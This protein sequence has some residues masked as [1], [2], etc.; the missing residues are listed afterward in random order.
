[1]KKKK[2]LKCLYFGFKMPKLAFKF[3]EMDPVG[4]G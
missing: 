4:F 2:P 3:N 1:M